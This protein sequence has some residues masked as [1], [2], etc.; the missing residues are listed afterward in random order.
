MQVLARES[1]PGMTGTSESCDM[2]QSVTCFLGMATMSSLVAVHFEPVRP[3]AV[4]LSFSD[5][6]GRR[7]MVSLLLIPVCEETKGWAEDWLCAATSEL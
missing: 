5:P 3:G 1:R 6:F 7:A 4:G 2:V